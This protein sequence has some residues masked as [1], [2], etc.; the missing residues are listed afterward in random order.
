MSAPLLV[1]EIDPGAGTPNNSYAAAGLRATSPRPAVI[2]FW[3]DCGISRR[4]LTSVG[5]LHCVKPDVEAASSRGIGEDV[6][7]MTSSVSDFHNV[8]Q[9]QN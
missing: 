5:N 9:S 3:N 6:F 1:S 2:R 4:S 7:N 8:M